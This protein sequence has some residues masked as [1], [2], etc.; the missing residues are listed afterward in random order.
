MEKTAKKVKKFRCWDCGSLN[1]IKWGERLGKQRFK[2]KNCGLL[3]TRSNSGV[4]HKNL[5]HWFREWIV[6]KQTFSQLVKSSGY[7]ERTL[8]RLFYSYLE[9]YPTWHINKKERV[10]LLIDGT[11]FANKVCLVLYRDNTVKTTLLYR[12]TD[13][14]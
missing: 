9:R 11:Y 2:C 6:G 3:L 13:G 7:S 8:K 1:T 14:E 10:N 12:L 5:E 4:K